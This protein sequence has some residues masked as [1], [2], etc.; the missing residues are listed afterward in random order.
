MYTAS[1]KCYADKVMDYLDPDKELIKYRLYRHD[2]VQV[3]QEDR[4][5]FVKDLRIF[6]N[7]D[8][9]NMI[10]IDNS[11]MSFAFQLDNGIPILPYYDNKSDCE[12]QFLVNYLKHLAKASDMQKENKN[13]IQLDQFL[14]KKVDENENSVNIDII[15]ADES[16]KGTNVYYN[17]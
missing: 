11:V 8:M 2:C 15:V 13:M 12:L 10:I 14:K 3:K 4:K 16:S 9:K 7:V 1:E 6:K 5:I 17:L